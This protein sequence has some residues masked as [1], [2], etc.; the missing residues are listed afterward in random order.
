MYTEHSNTVG[1]FID[2]NFELVFFKDM[3]DAYVAC[4]KNKRYNNSA[5]LF[6]MDYP[7]LLYELWADIIDGTYKIG[8]SI[9]FIIQIPR[10][11]EVF[12]ALFRDRIVHHLLYDKFNP[13]LDKYFIENS[14][15]CRPKKGTSLA[16]KTLS[17]IVEE[18]SCG[19]QKDCWIFKFDIKAFFM[20]INKN[21]QFSIL[22]KLVNRFYHEPDKEVLLHLSK[23]VIFDLP[24][25]KCIFNCKRSLWDNIDKGKTLFNKDA[26]HGQPIGNLTS[27]LFAN[28]V[29][30]LIDKIIL[31]MLPGIHYCRYADDSSYVVADK[32]LGLKILAKVKY[33]L[34]TKLD[35]ELHPNKIYIQ[36]FSKGVKFV[37]GVVKPNRNYISN[38][39][40]YGFEQLIEKYIKLSRE[41]PIQFRN[42]LDMFVSSVNSYLGTIS[43]Y[44]T[45]NFR[46]QLL[47]K[48]L[49]SPC[50]HYIYVPKG[51]S[52]IVLLNAYK[53][54]AIAEK[55]L[56]VMRK[57]A[58]YEQN[59]C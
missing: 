16:I 37:G 51:F 29:L 3:L 43:K 50:G 56:K 32:K 15:S 52:K 14:F 2:V 35:L 21:I 55:E 41:H 59:I 34:K 7:N 47:L 40:M 17:V 6:E 33:I 58:Y 36:H 48:L 53:K 1:L 25:T 57:I 49:C 31:A 9:A 44:A 39:V 22:E 19:Y 8:P 27:Q 38:K 12:A 5:V 11:R 24:Q 23:L 13:F 54:R 10:V 18:V 45:Y 30:D 26:N 46:K 42:N 20:S 4:R 28:M